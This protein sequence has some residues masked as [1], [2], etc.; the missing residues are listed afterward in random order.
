MSLY[1]KKVVAVLDTESTFGIKFQR[2][3]DDVK[4]LMLNSPQSFSTDGEVTLVDADND[5]GAG[6][7]GVAVGQFYRSGNVVKIRL[8]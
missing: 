1:G 4:G 8:S 3:V 2:L 6:E 7:A 5:R